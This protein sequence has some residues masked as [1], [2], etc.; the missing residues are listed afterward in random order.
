MFKVGD[1]VWAN[2]DRY[3]VTCYHRPCKVVISYGDGTIIADSIIFGGC[4]IYNVSKL[5]RS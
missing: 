1:K 4:F 2:T 3:R 5:D